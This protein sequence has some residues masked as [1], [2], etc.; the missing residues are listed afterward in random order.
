MFKAKVNIMLDEFAYMPVRAHETDAGMDLRAPEDVTIQPGGSAV[1][2]TGVH[3]QIP[4]GYY[5][6]L[7]SKSGLNVKHGVVSKGG[8]IDSG[9]TGSIKA[10][11]Y[12]DG[13]EPYTFHAG[14]KIVQLLIVPC[15]IPELVEVTGFP[16]TDR[17]ANG[18]GSSGR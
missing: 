17:C 2:D 10:K 8:V 1:I 3:I 12:N 4:A 18:F 13:S 16:D 6:K 14:D 11:L 15:M 7:E 5:G 9:Y